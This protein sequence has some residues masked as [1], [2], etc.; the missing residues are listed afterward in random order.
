MPLEL[1]WGVDGEVFTVTQEDFQKNSR[2]IFGYDYTHSNLKGLRDLF[3]NANTLYAY[4]LNSGEKASNTYAT[5]TCSG[6]RGNDIKI[7]ISVNADNAEQFDVKT[8][9]DNV[10]VDSQTVTTASELVA[11]DYVVFKPDVTL[12]V[13]AGVNLSGGINGTV[14]GATHQAFL[15]KIESY[16]FNTLGVLTAEDT[17]KSLYVSFT[18]RLRDEMGVKFQIILHTKS[19]DY[20]GVINVAN[21]TTDP[22]NPVSSLVYWVTGASAACPVNKTNLNKVYDGEFTIDVDYTQSELVTA[23]KDGKYI[24][25]KVG[26][27]IRVLADINSLVTVTQEKGEDFK[28]NQTIRVL[29]QIGN[30]V[31]TLFNT[32]YLG[33]MP[34]DENGRLMLWND[35]VKY[36][37]QL[38]DLRAIEN[39]TDA[40]VTV[41]Q[42]STKKT[43]IISC[44]V[45]VVNAMAQLYMSIVVQ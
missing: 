15:D 18:K 7:V 8:Y 44:P 5:A 23:I 38:Q 20:E 39:F 4:R 34:N 2:K 12:E 21:N 43:V 45:T 14:D 10:L 40:N 29:D 41:E 16:S 32:S 24:L 33:S 19:A 31:A 22:D 42:G 35:L 37:R 25:H 28:E 11:N 3:I 6:V 27:S 13:I 1:D 17:I 36:F 26:D 9:L 30:D